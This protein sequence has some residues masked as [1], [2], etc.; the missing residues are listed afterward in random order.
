MKIRGNTVGT[1]MRPDKAVVVASEVMNE[2]QKALVRNNIG[3]A[4]AEAIGDIESALDTIIAIQEELINN[5]GGGDYEYYCDNCGAGMNDLW[6]CDNC[7]TSYSQCEWCGTRYIDEG[8]PPPCGCDGG[9]SGDGNACPNCGETLDESGWCPNSCQEMEITFYI[10]DT[11][12]TYRSGMTWEDFV[13]S[14]YNRKGLTCEECGSEN[15][16]FSITDESVYYFTG[17]CCGI[18]SVPLVYDEES[19][20]IVYPNEAIESGHNYVW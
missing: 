15:D 7:G 9:S 13:N 11:P 5:G 14:G 12:H 19:R 6:Y 16:E 10:Y 4:S 18:G 8:G 1:P 3:A 20:Q 17:T 2:E